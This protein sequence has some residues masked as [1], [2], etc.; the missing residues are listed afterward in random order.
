MNTS[1]FLDFLR[2]RLGLLVA[3]GLILVIVLGLAG[4]LRPDGGV[5]PVTLYEPTPAGAATS[6][7]RP[8]VPIVPSPP[9]PE[10]TNVPLPRLS[11]LV[12][13]SATASR[14]G[15]VAPYGRLLRCQLVNTVDSAKIDTPIIALLTDDVWHDGQLVVPVGTEIHGRAK[16]DRSRERIVAEGEW[17]LVWQTGR[18]LVVTGIALDREEHPSLLTWGITDGSAG[19]RGQL[20][21][22]DLLAEVKLFVATFMS[23]MASGLQDSQRTLLGTEIPGTARNAALD[24]VSSVLDRYAEGLAEL[25]RRD[26]VYLR[27]PAGKQMYLYV[28]D[29]LDLSRPGPRPLPAAPVLPV[30]S[31]NPPPQTPTP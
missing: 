31:T 2:T 17:T 25:V 18:E 5:S 30:A 9:R 6:I 10:S 15:V 28:T 11:I 26:G 20:L 16:L 12:P 1:S 29:Q 27:V 24:G 19:L 23:G 21:H 8:T 13:L 14:P 22:S 7:D 3:V 4:A